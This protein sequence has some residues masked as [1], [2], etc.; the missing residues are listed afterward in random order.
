MTSVMTSPWVTS[1]RRLTDPVRP[2]KV[3]SANRPE[4]IATSHVCVILYVFY[5]AECT[6]PAFVTNDDSCKS[7][8]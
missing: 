6:P 1:Q 5:D 8:S 3:V 4:R 7:Y 2:F